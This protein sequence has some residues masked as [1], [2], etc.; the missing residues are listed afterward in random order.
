MSAYLF[1]C[2][3]VF[4]SVCLS[5]NPT[6]HANLNRSVGPYIEDML[7]SFDRG[8][9]ICA[10]YNKRETEFCLFVCLFLLLYVPCQQLWSLRDGQLT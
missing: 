1:V 8:I 5:I 4:E 10:V 6:A 2:L 7:W 3:S 9:G